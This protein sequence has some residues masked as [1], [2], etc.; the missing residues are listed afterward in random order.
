MDSVILKP[1]ITYIHLSLLCIIHVAVTPPPILIL[2]AKLVSYKPII[3]PQISL[4]NI[5]A[6]AAE[7]LNYIF[8]INS[9]C[10]EILKKD[11]FSSSTLSQV[12]TL[13]SSF[14]P[15]AS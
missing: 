11:D 12:W 13:F 15:V 5:A 8:L 1:H 3:E 6:K 4:M 14:F 2:Y 10:R 9:Y 7:G